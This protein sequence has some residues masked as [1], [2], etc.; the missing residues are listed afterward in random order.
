MKLDQTITKKQYLH[1]K[2]V[3]YLVIIIM[4]V[5]SGW[6]SYLTW[7]NPLGLNPELDP[8]Q[9]NGALPFTPPVEFESSITLPDGRPIILNDRELESS[10]TVAEV[11]EE[12]HSMPQL[13]DEE[14][15]EKSQ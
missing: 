4:I 13:T 8:K 9:H 12:L 14:F 2:L 6:A 15:Q 7:L 3:V 5:I 1:Y 11:F 10:P